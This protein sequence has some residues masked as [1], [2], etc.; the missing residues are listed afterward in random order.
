MFPR[1][2]LTLNVLAWCALP[3]LAQAVALPPVIAEAAAKLSSLVTV[4]RIGEAAPD[5][6]VDALVARVDVLL[7]A[8]DL[9]AATDAIKL[10]K[11]KPAEV[12]APWLR[13]ADARLVAEQA[14]ANLHIHAL[15]LLAPAKAGG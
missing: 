3:C 10:L 2:L 8:G 6:S 4:R 5:D 1:Y 12:V 14:V 15:S 9:R 7:S 13:A 11:G